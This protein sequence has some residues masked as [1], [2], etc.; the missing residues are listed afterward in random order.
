VQ[1]RYDL[2]TEADCTEL[3]GTWDEWER[4][5][6]SGE[7]SCFYCKI[8]FDTMSLSEFTFPREK[9]SFAD[10]PSEFLIYFYRVPN[11]GQGEIIV[12][13]SV[14]TLIITLKHQNGQT[15]T[16]DIDTSGPVAQIEPG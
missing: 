7:S 2:E 16:L 8:D 3:G 6:P 12:P 9:V 13:A 1:Y 4:D 5:C 11:A 14:E 15:V 10:D